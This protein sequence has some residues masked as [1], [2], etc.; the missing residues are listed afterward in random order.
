MHG[1]EEGMNEMIEQG[2]DGTFVHMNRGTCS[3]AVAFTLDEAERVHDVRFEG[4]CDGNLKGV[5]RLVEG[6]PAA[7][8]AERL[9]GTECGFKKTSCPDQL[10]QALSEA[11]GA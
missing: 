5:G 3:R 9:A 2:A 10:A 6:M 1:E 7:E 4:G 11:L 8:V